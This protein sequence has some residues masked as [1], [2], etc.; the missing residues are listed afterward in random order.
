M[1]VTILSCGFVFRILYGG[2]ID[3]IEVS[4][5]LFMTVLTMALFFSLGKRRNEIRTNRDGRTRSVLE[6]Y[7]AA[8]LD[9]GMYMCLT[10]G[11]VFYALWTMDAATE[12]RYPK[13]PMIYSFPIVLL[14]TLRY[15]LL[16]ERESDG[17]PVEV[18]LHDRTILALCLIYVLALSASRYL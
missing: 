16:I 6:R 1:D 5:W 14:I 17:D 8:F 9:K 13:F 12:I 11:N 4:D 15:C 2:A 3:G 7:P 10:L 18:V